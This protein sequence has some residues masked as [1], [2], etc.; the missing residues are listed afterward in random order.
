MRKCDIRPP[1]TPSRIPQGDD[2]NDT[3]NADYAAPLLRVSLGIMFI[4]RAPQVLRVHAA[5]HRAVLRFDRT[6]RR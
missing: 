4:A 3:R 6:A 5:R 1:R 2:M